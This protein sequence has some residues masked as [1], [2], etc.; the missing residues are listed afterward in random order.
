[1]GGEP[2]FDFFANE[3]RY[4]MHVLP[5]YCR[6]PGIDRPDGRYTL[7]RPICIHGLRVPRVTGSTRLWWG[8]T[9]AALK[10]GSVRV[11]ELPSPVL[12]EVRGTLLPLGC[13]QDRETH[14]PIAL[15]ATNRVAIVQPGVV[16]HVHSGL[17]RIK[18]TYELLPRLIT[19]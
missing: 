7:R 18:L 15:M 13:I 14:H 6:F 8:R 11:R 19:V 16:R 12:S 2:A 3:D 10:S 17:V 4:F 9:H 1:M 5:G